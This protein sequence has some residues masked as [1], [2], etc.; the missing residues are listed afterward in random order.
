MPLFDFKC[1]T[2]DTIFERICTYQSTD[3]QVCPNCVSENTVRQL[4]TPH[5]VRSGT[6]F[7]R[8]KIPSD[9]K[10]GVLNRIKT[11][12]KSPTDTIKI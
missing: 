12:Y 3:I 10:D 6:L 11:N 2:C 7:N 5:I 1:L 4:C 9:F 8:S